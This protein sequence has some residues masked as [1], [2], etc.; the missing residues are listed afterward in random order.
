[1]VD[2]APACLISCFLPVLQFDF[3][4]CSQ[5]QHE[6]SLAA[7]HHALYN[8]L[9]SL[10]NELTQLSRSNRATERHIEEQKA[11]REL[12]KES[13]QLKERSKNSSCSS[14][15]RRR[16]QS[17]AETDESTSTLMKDRIKH[18]D[19]E[20]EEDDISPDHVEST[21]PSSSSSPSTRQRKKRK[22]THLK[23]LTLV[24]SKQANTKSHRKRKL[25]QEN[26]PF[27]SNNPQQQQFY[28]TTSSNTNVSSGGAPTR[29]KASNPHH[30]LLEDEQDSHSR[31][32][33]LAKRDFV[34]SNA[35]TQEKVKADRSGELNLNGCYPE[36]EED[37]E[38][39]AYI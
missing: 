26:L 18:D 23:P 15:R 24:D 11:L 7:P 38:A 28:S 8:E 22:S 14:N 27:S 30:I 31:S 39:E 3:L 4:V 35:V 34:Q 6:A 16:R 2:D 25:R 1:M 33:S 36:E 21:P 9:V 13:H 20:D 12:D 29:L 19:D 32:W 5:L 17:S 37:Q 10:R